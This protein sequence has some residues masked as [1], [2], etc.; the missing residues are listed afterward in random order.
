MLCDVSYYRVVLQFCLGQIS[1]AVLCVCVHVL[2]SSS[3]KMSSFPLKLKVT[4]FFE[5]WELLAE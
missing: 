3:V 1:R 2:S 4:F 5:T